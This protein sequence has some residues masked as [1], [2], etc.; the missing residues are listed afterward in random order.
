MWPGSPPELG[1]V[2]DRT[3]EQAA[4]R[5]GRLVPGARHNTDTNNGHMMLTD[6]PPLV[7]DAIAEVVAAVRDGRTRALP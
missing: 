4:S 6:Q 3:N 7:I 2:I 5:V 1:A